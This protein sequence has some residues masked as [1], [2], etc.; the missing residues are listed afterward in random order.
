MKILTE[1]G[2]MKFKG[3][4]KK[5]SSCLKL[6]FDNGETLICS[7][8][9]QIKLMNGDFLFANELR[10]GDAIKY[11]QADFVVIEKIE[12][13]GQ[14]D[15]YSPIEVSGGHEYV[16]KCMTHHNCS[17][18][19]SSSTLIDGEILDKMTSVDPASYK[20]GYDMKIFEEPMPNALYVMGVDSAMGNGGDYSAIQVI[21][22][23]KRGQ[24]K[25]VAVYKR[26]TIDT[27][28]FAEVVNAI[29][30]YYNDAQYIIEN[31]DLGRLVADKLFYDIGNGNMI[32]TDKHNLGTRANR[33]TKLEA[34][35][36]LKGMAEHKELEI[37]DEDTIDQLS[38]FEEISPN[39]FR[40]AKGQHDD[41]VSAL[42]WACYCLT[43]PEIDL[44]N[45][46]VSEKA[47]EDALPPPMYA[48]FGGSNPF[49][50]GINASN[51]WDNLR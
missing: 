39:V 12:N 32:S 43:Q 27:D 29:S 11:G 9:H 13:A 28:G 14:R 50:V 25:Q 16:A 6:F 7:C 41:L 8:D 33:D 49:G 19:G 36:I 34:C 15:V 48:D 38:R 18:I 44:D 1:N 47:H 46:K 40:A 45:V 4:Q 24:Y 23:L 35:K 30:N 20:Y 31:N 5:K 22:I 37:C 10:N 17:F 3:I 51:F 26:N 21:K 2:F 42:Y